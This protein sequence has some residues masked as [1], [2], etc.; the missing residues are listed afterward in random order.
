[1]KTGTFLY[2]CSLVTILGGAVLGSTLAISQ[3]S[4]DYKFFDPLVDIKA[5]ISQRYVEEPDLE[6]LQRGAIEGLIEALNDPYTVYVSAEDRR[7]FDKALTGDYVGI[8]VSITIKDGWLTVLSPLEDTPAFKA[9][10]QA[11]DRIAEIEGTS[12]LGLDTDKCIDLLSGTPGTS[13]NIVI[14]REEERIP[15]TITRERIIA[16][17][18]KGVHWNGGGESRGGWDYL[19]DPRRKIGYLRLTQFTPSSSQELTRAIESLGA[20]EGQ[21]G[22]LI[23]DLRWNP[24]GVLNEATAIADLFLKEGVI[25]STRG[26]ATDEEVYRAREEGTLPEFPLVVLVNGQSASASEVLSG[27][28]ADH[29]RAIVIGTRTFGKGLVQSVIG[30]PSGDGAQ[31][32][33]TEQRYYLPSGRCIQRTDD[34]P[35]WGVDPTDGFYVPMT[36]E[37]LTASL[38]IRADEDVIR[39]ASAASPEEGGWADPEWILEH[40]KDKQL[41][42]AVRAVQGKIDTG[43]WT[44]TGE[45]V[46]AGEQLALDDLK[47]SQLL[48]ER[49][50]RE[51]D[52]VERRIESLEVAAAE[53]AETLEF[54]LWPDDTDLSGGRLV[55]YDKDGNPV[56]KLRIEGADLERW[57]IDAGVKPEGK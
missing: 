34:S 24:G 46:K 2:Q 13:V 25:V 23:L 6:T 27:A 54:D 56:S 55:V 31:L 42:A 48:R 33:I 8:G 10:I 3:R 28:L 35:V 20:R 38:R 49:L 32:K 40:L 5:I 51:L 29:G 7:E 17:T 19:I 43:E 57:L 45:P 37:E 15:M 21:L 18:V 50:L 47:K 9:G 26:R 14:E 30:L 1:M 12:T 44:P 4:S 52:R 22:G 36:D 11:G 53:G 39:A 16:K 41:A